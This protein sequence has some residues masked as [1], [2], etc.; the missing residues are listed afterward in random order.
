MSEVRL[1]YLCVDCDEIMELDE[2]DVINDERLTHRCKYNKKKNL[3]RTKTCKLYD[4]ENYCKKSKATHNS[5]LEL[6]EEY[7]H[8]ASI[9]HLFNDKL[10]ARLPRAHNVID[11]DNVNDDNNDNDLDINDENK[12]NSNIDLHTQKKRS[13][14]IFD[15]N[16]TYTPPQKKHKKDTNKA[17]QKISS[18]EA[19]KKVKFTIVFVFLYHDC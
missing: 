7:D 11:D 6:I 3:S 4:K 12:N 18:L 16:D 19:A 8:Y 13:Q 10:K 15:D 14:S 9:Y 17:P 2:N 1:H 5:C